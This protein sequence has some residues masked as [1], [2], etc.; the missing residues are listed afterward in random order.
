MAD[1]GFCRCETSGTLACT[2][3]PLCLVQS[4]RRIIRRHDSMI[5]QTKCFDA[6]GQASMRKNETVKF[7]QTAQQDELRANVSGLSRFS[8][9]FFAIPWNNESYER[10]FNVNT[11]LLHASGSPDHWRVALPTG[12]GFVPFGQI[13]ESGAR[14]RAEAPFICCRR[15]G[16][17]CTIRID[18]IGTRS[19]G[20]RQ[21]AVP[22]R[23]LRFGSRRAA[24]RRRLHPCFQPWVPRRPWLGGH[25]RRFVV[26]WP[27][28]FWGSDGTGRNRHSIAR[29]APSVGGGCLVFLGLRV[30][31]DGVAAG[32]RHLPDGRPDFRLYL[33]AWLDSRG[34]RPNVLHVVGSAGRFPKPNVLA[35]GFE[36]HRVG[37][38]SLRTDTRKIAEKMADCGRLWLEKLNNHKLP[39]HSG[40]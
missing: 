28:L 7:S 24:E 1:L 10:F 35:F 32:E 13:L 29:I 23:F 20:I 4:S 11:Q 36:R 15:H 21:R 18:I 2:V 34:T 12:S 9:D 40:R 39:G 22:S 6:A 14:L 19:L 3:Y 27:R 37:K 8:V 26:G 38:Q 31:R 17:S 25:R 5:R 16:L 30:Y 33:P